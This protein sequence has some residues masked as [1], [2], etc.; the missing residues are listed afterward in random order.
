MLHDD[1]DGAQMVAWT[2]TP[3]TLPSNLSLCVH[4]EMIYVK[5]RCSSR[6]RI[7]PGHNHVG[8]TRGICVSTGTQKL[9]VAALLAQVRNPDSGAT[10]ILLE[11]RLGELPG[12][13]GK[14]AKKD[15]KGKKSDEPA[16]P[17]FQVPYHQETS[18]TRIKSTLFPTAYAAGLVP[19]P[20]LLSDFMLK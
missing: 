16:V 9:C 4:P 6:D 7:Q 20:R 15:K 18:L 3:W 2:T 5:V 12:A 11:E 17:P 14:P 19:C 10:Y 1:P 8:D 13:L